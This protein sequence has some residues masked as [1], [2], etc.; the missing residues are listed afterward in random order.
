M[1]YF[2]AFF[3]CAVSS[4][5][6]A[7][8][9]C[10]NT[11]PASCFE[12]P[13]SSG[14]QS[15]GTHAGTS[16]DPL[17]CWTDF[18]SNA[19]FGDQVTLNTGTYS[20]ELFIPAS[21]GGSTSNGYVKMYG[22]GTIPADGIQGPSATH[23]IINA[24]GRDIFFTIGWTNVDIRNIEFANG[25]TANTACGFMQTTGSGPGPV[26]SHL[27]FRH[28]LV[29]S[30]GSDSIQF[31]G[32]D[33]L[34]EQ[35]NIIH[36]N[37]SAEGTFSQSAIHLYQFTNSDTLPGYHNIINGN[38][39]YLESKGTGA[40][41]D[42]MGIEF[43]DFDG[44]QNSWCTNHASGCPYTGASL[45]TNNQIAFNDGDCIHWFSSTHTG[46]D[47][48]NNSCF[49]ND[50][51]QAS[52]GVYGE[53]SVNGATTGVNL[54]NNIIVPQSSSYYAVNLDAATTVTIDYND[55]FGAAGNVTQTGSSGITIGSHSVTGNPLLRFA[56]AT[57]PN[58]T[59]APGSAAFGVGNLTHTTLLDYS[60]STRTGFLSNCSG[61]KIDIG[62]KELN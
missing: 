49:K 25:N 41:T 38:L 15:C 31:A 61:A 39:I 57:V 24:A 26:G 47:G 43:D 18:L 9:A 58:L 5:A 16:G 52:G 21:F 19:Q 17:V 37:G 22:A 27:I 62:A 60:N 4:A 30:C 45:V 32:M 23:A 35:W 46:F 54:Y 40:G 50:A 33:Y 12:N 8:P 11:H 3:L 10:L 36:N 13:F 14:T 29:D 53:L 1:R 42:G 48:W 28:N 6:F 51:A 2:L 56:N 34:D 44:T 55:Y 20:V 59:P 7:A